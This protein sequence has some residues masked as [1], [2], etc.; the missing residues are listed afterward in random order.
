[1]LALLHVT[2][3]SIHSYVTFSSLTICSL[4]SSF[5]SRGEVGATRLLR[6]WIVSGSSWSVGGGRFEVV[7]C[8]W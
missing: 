1:V 3:I 4:R 7:V 2:L 6:R 8:V 5:G